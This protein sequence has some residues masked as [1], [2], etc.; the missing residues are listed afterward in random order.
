MK[1]INTIIWDWNGT[2][3][4]DIDI[5]IESINEL[6]VLRNQP[7]LNK[8][9]YREI[10]TFPVRDYYIKAGFDF[11]HEPFNKIALEFIQ[12]Y[13]QKLSQASIFH[14]VIEILDFFKKHNYKQLM[15]SAMEHESLCNSVE[16]QGILTYFD[17]I[18]GISDHFATS[19]LENAKKFV[20]DLHL[21]V[22]QSCLIGDTMH[23]FEVAHEMGMDCLLISNGHQ[24]YNRLV[25]SKCLVVKELK[26]VMNVFKSN[27]KFADS[28]VL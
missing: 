20:K 25:K 15:V 16:E 27:Y 21:D 18:S 22:S 8:G 19:K 4:N 1:K 26:D 9:I 7:I 12:R 3:L 10:F 2:L 11:T 24:S 17:Q 5:C 13:Q 6:L 28:V 23:D 14:G